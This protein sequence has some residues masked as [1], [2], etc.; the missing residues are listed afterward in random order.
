MDRQKTKKTQ[1]YCHLKISRGKEKALK[2][3]FMYLLLE[4]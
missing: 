3:L 4:P 2:W 1:N